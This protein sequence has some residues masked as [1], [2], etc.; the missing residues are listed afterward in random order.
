MGGEGNTQKDKVRVPAA[1]IP[2]PQLLSFPAP[3]WSI[4]HSLS[5]QSSSSRCPFLA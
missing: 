1:V 2:D 3:G 5:Y 4:L